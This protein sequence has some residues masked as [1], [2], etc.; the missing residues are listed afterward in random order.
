MSRNTPRR[1]SSRAGTSRPRRLAGQRPATPEE[2]EAAGSEGPADDRVDASPAAGE[3]EPE[4]RPARGDADDAP[5]AGL[6]VGLSGERTTRVL[7]VAMAVL[8]LLLVAQGIW[9]VVHSVRD[10]PAADVPEGEIAVPSGRPV[11]MSEVAW[12]E[13]VD[14]AAEAATTVVARDYEKY[15]AEVDEAI[16]LMTPSFAEEYRKI[17]SDIKSEFVDQR[18]VVE[19][20]VVGQGV[21]RA[22]QTEL[23]ALVF[24]NQY[25]TKGP[26]KDSETTYAPYRAVLTMVHT[27]EGWLVDDIQTK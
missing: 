7:M 26:A 10:E 27:D 18:T 6:A 16:A 3:D 12:R 2:L 24:L 19:V 14:A 17:T 21:V 15:D 23:Q 13:G 20:R 25:T 4:D 22:N 1:S 8:T 11:V 9:W 5:D